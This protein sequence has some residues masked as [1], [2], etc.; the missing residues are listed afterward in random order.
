MADSFPLAELIEVRGK[1]VGGNGKVLVEE[2]E[3]VGVTSRQAR[4]TGVFLQSDKFDTIAGGEDE[5]FTNARMMDESAGGIRE[6]SGG[7]GKA[8]THLDGRGDVVDAEKNEFLA[9]AHGVVNLWTAL[10]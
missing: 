2:V 9:G 7:Y 3:Q 8:F 4:F 10:N 5:A 1:G 6:A